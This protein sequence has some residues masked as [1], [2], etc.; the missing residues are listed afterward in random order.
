MA[1]KVSQTE[2]GK[3]I[4]G[5]SLDPENFKEFKA[6]GRF[7]NG[8]VFDQASPDHPVIICYWSKYGIL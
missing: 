5:E 7:I 4:R 3:W 8:Y 2:S 1:E 6:A